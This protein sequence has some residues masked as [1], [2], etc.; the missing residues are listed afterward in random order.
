MRQYTSAPELHFHGV[1]DSNVI[2][3]K[4][5]ETLRTEDQNRR[6]ADHPVEDDDS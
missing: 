6:D 2:A 3:S 1:T 5:R 4:V